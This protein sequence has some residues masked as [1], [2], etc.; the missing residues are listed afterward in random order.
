MRTCRKVILSFHLIFSILLTLTFSTFL[1]SFQQK[2]FLDHFLYCFSHFYLLFS[3][4]TCLC[5]CFSLAYA[6]PA[7][8]LHLLHSPHSFV[9]PRSPSLLT[10]RH[11][12]PLSFQCV[13]DGETRSRSKSG[14]KLG[15]A[16]NCVVGKHCV[17]TCAL[18]L[19]IFISTKQYD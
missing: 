6:L 14:K 5:V 1:P 11:F 19:S 8:L 16:T 9:V 17:G 3:V 13:K 15:M 7:F 18:S 4:P 2:C 10:H 12:L